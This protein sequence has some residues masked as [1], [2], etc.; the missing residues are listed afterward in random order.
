MVTSVQGADYGLRILY[1]GHRNTLGFL[2]ANGFTK[3]NYVAGTTINTTLSAATPK[4]VLAGSVAVVKGTDMIG[5]P[6]PAASPDVSETP[7]GLFINDAAGYAFQSTSAAAS[8][9]APYVDSMG[10]FEV[11]YYETNLRDA[12]G[13]HTA[14]TLVYAAGD[15][16]YCDSRSGLLTNVPPD[17]LANVPPVITNGMIAAN[18]NQPVAILTRVPTTADISMRIALRV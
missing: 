15:K 9:R 3:V 18:N 16:L 10:T 12:Y 2:D 13:I 11:R 4:G 6:T 1:V 7:L 8:G 5:G 17:D 14:T